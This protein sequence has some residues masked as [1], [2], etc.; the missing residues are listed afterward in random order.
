MQFL[1]DCLAGAVVCAGLF[2]PFALSEKLIAGH[3]QLNRSRQPNPLMF[4]RPLTDFLKLRGFRGN[5]ADHV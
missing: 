5:D 4:T 1:F 2:S 3:Q